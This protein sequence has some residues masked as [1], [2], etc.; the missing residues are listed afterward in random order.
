MTEPTPESD[1]DLAQQLRTLG[2]AVES[3]TA[4]TTTQQILDAPPSID[5][6]RP[7]APAPTEQD[8]HRSRLIPL[9][10]AAALVIAA[11]GGYALFAR[12]DPS[13]DLQLAA[14]AQPAEPSAPPDDN[15]WEELRFCE[16][17]GTYDIDTGNTFYGAY[18]FTWE[19]WRSTASQIG[20]ESISR[21]NP[22]EASPAIQDAMA[23]ALYDERGDDAWP[24][25]GRF[26][27]GPMITPLVP[28]WMAELPE[29]HLG[30]EIIVFVKP[31]ATPSQEEGVRD[32]LRKILGLNFER[33]VTFVDK[34]DA[35]AEFQEM[36]ADQEEISESVTVSDM[37]SSYRIEAGLSPMILDTL[38]DL[39]GVFEVVYANPFELAPLPRKLTIPRL[40]IDTPLFTDPSAPELSAGAGVIN[41]SERGLLVAGYGSF[42]G[43]IFGELSMLSLGDVVQLSELVD[44]RDATFEMVHTYEVVA[45]PEVVAVSEL[46]A[47]GETASGEVRELVGLV[48]VADVPDDP[49]MRTVVRLLLAAPDRESYGLGGS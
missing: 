32:Y 34:A 15:G 37:P 22:A 28:Q 29:E 27:T 3:R 42:D 17:T 4:A 12:P 23:A 31:D 9:M 39:E 44:N 40:A 43:S 49:T 18:Q 2:Q 16:S 19:T 1:A 36:F 38:E 13:A 45:A 24:V 33:K 47:F 11:I 30:V 20:L 46:E 35:Y 26:I 41:E 25:C 5:V 14:A 6:D 7:Q 21:T 48:L 8:Q 10:A